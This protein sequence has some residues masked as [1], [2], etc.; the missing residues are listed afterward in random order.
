VLLTTEPSL[1][2]LLGSALNGRVYVSGRDCG[3]SLLF[4]VYTVHA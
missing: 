2:L 3:D 1:Q 4:K